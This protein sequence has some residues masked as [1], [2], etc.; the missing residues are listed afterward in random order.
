MRTAF[1]LLC[2]LA[3]LPIAAATQQPQPAPCSAPE[4]RQFDFWVGDWEL[5]WPASASSERKPGQ[6][7]NHIEIVLDKC[8]IV[9]RFDGTPATSLR[10]MS[11]STFNARTRQWQQ[12]WVD[13]DGSY[14]DFIGGFKNGQLL[15]NS[16]KSV[17]QMA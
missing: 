16:S 15:G 11:V 12:T 9:E 4:F 8:V 17:R 10:G 13:N 3:L 2:L 5:S 14:L 7:V 6:G 1:V